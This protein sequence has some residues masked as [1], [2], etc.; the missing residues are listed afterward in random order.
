MIL[1]PRQCRTVSVVNLFHNREHHKEEKKRFLS[2]QMAGTKSQEN[3]SKILLFGF[4][5]KSK[6]NESILHIPVNKSDA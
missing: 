2:M 1:F 3:I 4:D 5:V 6:F